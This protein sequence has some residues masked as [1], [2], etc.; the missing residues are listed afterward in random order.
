MYCFIFVA[1]MTFTTFL[2]ADVRSVEEKDFQN[3]IAKGTVVVDFYGPWCGPCK[4]LA[5]VLDQLSDEMEGKVTFIKINID[6]AQAITDKYEVTGVPALV[7][8][9][10]GKEQGRVVGFRDKSAVKKFI[11]SGGKS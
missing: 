5:P 3:E 8:F 1:V 11:E 10:N 6:N 9:K 7:L 2:G 4:R